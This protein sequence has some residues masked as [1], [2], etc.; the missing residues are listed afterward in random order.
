MARRTGEYR[1]GDVFSIRLNAETAD[2]LRWAARESG[3]TVSDLFRRSLRPIL[4]V[5]RADWYEK[6]GSEDDWVEVK[7]V[8]PVTSRRLKS[9]FGV[10]LD[11]EEVVAIGDAARACGVS[12]SAYLRE[13]GL[14]VATAQRAGGTARCPHLSMGPVTS[15]ECHVCGPLP[16][17]YTVSPA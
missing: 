2:E 12:I 8:G 17:T 3:K 5:I 14:A 9:S 4:A 15:A 11:Y 10:G 16:V 1:A 7:A 6:H 13:A